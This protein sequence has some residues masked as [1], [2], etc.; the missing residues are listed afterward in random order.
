MAGEVKR[1]LNLDAILGEIG[2]S[3]LFHT[4]IYCMLMVPVMLFSMY[5]M[6]FLFTS[7]RLNYR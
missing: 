6:T 7:A 3:G 2:S 1:D 4:R 5:D